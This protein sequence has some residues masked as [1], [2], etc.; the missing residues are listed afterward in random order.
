MRLVEFK[1]LREVSY[2]RDFRRV[3]FGL[4]RDL[5]VGFCRKLSW[6]ER[7]LEDLVDLQGQPPQ[8][9]GVIHLSVQKVKHAGKRPAWMN[10]ELLAELKCKKKCTQVA[11][12]IRLPGT[13]AKMLPTHVEM[14]SGKPNLVVVETSKA[15]EGWQER[16]F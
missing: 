1:I 16:F 5:L 14:E 10:P 6:K 4:F 15:S 12:G 8:S 9:T 11:A 7:G 13:N 2:I 3:G